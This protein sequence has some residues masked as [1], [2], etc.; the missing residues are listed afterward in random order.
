MEYDLNVFSVRNVWDLFS[1]YIEDELQEKSK[2]FSCE[3]RNS[4]D[5][6]P[7]ISY[8]FYRDKRMLMQNETYCKK[9]KL[10]ATM[11]EQRNTK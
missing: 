8:V 10:R 11:E 4:C 9:A 3:Y 5:Y 1:E 7:A 2:C 6:C